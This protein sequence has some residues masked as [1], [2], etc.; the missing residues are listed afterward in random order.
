MVFS[1]GEKSPK[2][3]LEVGLYISEDALWFGEWLRNIR[4]SIWLGLGSSGK[5]WRLFPA[6]PHKAIKDTE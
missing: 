3:R 5:I 2:G 1:K 6:V 4:T